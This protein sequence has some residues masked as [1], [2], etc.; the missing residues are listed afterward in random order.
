M[1]KIV[2]SVGM[3]ALGASGLQASAAV[4]DVAG[5]KPWSIGASLRGFYDDNVN[6]VSSGYPFGPG[7]QRDS[8]GFE[9]SPSL[10]LAWAVEQTSLTFAYVY[11][12]KYYEEKPINNTDHYDQTH[13]FNF[14][15]EH[16]FS[17]RY[18][19]SVKDAFVLGQEPDVLRAGNINNSFQ[20][21]PGDNIRNTGTITFNAA[22]T[23]VIG[24][25]AGYQNNY[26]DYAANT[27]VFDALGNVTQPSLAGVLNRMEHTFHLDGRWEWKPKT[28]VIVGYQF[29]E[30][31][32][33]G[34]QAIGV[35]PNP[36]GP[37][38]SAYGTNLFSDVRNN[39]SQLGYLGLDQTFSPELSASVRAGG[40][41]ND[42]YNDPT[43]QNEPSPYFTG[44]L[45]YTYGIE[46]YLEVGT[47]YDRS[48]T[49]LFGI[50]TTG[51]QTTITTDAQTLGLW[52][53]W[54]HRITP[55]L[56]GSILAQFQDNVYQ[57]G[58]FNNET[59]LFYLLG[60]NL[61]Y[62]FTTHFAAELG[63]NYDRL[64]SNSSLN[65][66]IPTGRSFDRNRIYLGVS[67]NY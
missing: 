41:Y 38:F 32:Y 45:H 31:D 34:N 1:N 3:V 22:L 49:D 24:L 21:V 25:E 40:R 23:P 12:L 4:L 48:A 46:S 35:N 15:L 36:G 43:S 7:Q 29:V 5:Q 60:I 64:D 66:Q 14:D 17:P 67:A 28:I 47:S 16:T 42:Y 39:R 65:A 59:D 54:N 18:Q 20:R 63:Y 53:S 52:V 11:S 56:H 2:A 10:N 27:A 57:G 6:S 30:V 9:I 61:R 55:K 8:F 37:P 44:S 19:A 50:S 62:N 51:S 58:S 26:A 13:T 33:T